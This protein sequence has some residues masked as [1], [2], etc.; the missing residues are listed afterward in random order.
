MNWADEDDG[1]FTH[2]GTPSGFVC[3]ECQG[4]LYRSR[5]GWVTWASVYSK[6]GK[7]AGRVQHYRCGRAH[8]AHKA[9]KV[10]RARA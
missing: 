6:D 7:Y 9:V 10:V 1:G 4:V 5:F 8:S 2:E 3:T